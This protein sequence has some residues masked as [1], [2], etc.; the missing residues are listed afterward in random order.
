MYP[1]FITD[2]EM[3]ETAVPTL[4]GQKRWGVGKLE[5][6]SPRAFS[7]GVLPKADFIRSSSLGLLS[8]RA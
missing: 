5:G 7:L 1:I 3:E 4:P 6:V 2:N 8:P